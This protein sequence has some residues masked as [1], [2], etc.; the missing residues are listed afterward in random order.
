MPKRPDKKTSVRQPREARLEPVISRA[1][2]LRAE[3]K[4]L[5]EIG[6][7]LGVSHVMARNYILKGLDRLR[8]DTLNNADNLRQIEL[9][10]LDAIIKAWWSEAV[11]VRLD[12]ND[13]PS[14]KGAE[15]VLKA[16][17]QRC[18]LLGLNAPIKVDARVSFN[19]QPLDLSVYT[20]AEL[21]TL[22][23]LL[24]KQPWGARLLGDVRDPI[25]DAEF[26]EVADPG[27]D[28]DPSASEV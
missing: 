10:R 14:T 25:L 23:G 28:P 8:E 5:A 18:D 13:I 26:S 19:P 20:D 21:D 27:E 4:S 12:R 6:E 1:L 11:N 24:A 3:G 22:Q 7:E 15:L 9:A 16:I 2:E 17:K